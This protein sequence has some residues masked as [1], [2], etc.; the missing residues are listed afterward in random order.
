MVTIA[1]NYDTSVNTD[2]NYTLPSK[3]TKKA[4]LRING[5]M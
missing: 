5:A 1:V 2:I 3:P 4:L